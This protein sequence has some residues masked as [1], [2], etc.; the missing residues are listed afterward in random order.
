MKWQWT[1]GPT[2]LHGLI[3]TQFLY[4][5]CVGL[6]ETPIYF[7]LGLINP[8]NIIDPINIINLPSPDLCGVLQACYSGIKMGFDQKI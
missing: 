2:L 8:I 5:W 7:F 3:G 6:P 4:H 1:Y